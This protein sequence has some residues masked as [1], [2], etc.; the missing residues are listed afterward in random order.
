MIDPTPHL[1]ALPKLGPYR[2]L[3]SGKVRD[4]YEVD[5][6]HLLFVT[7]DRVSAFD[8]IMP[9]GIPG[10]GRVLTA[11][12]THWFQHTEDIL[13]NHLVS[14]DVEGLPHHGELSD[15]ERALLRGRMMLVRK[16][17]PTPVEWVVRAYVCGSGWKEYEKQGTICGI[18]L[19]AGIPFCGRLPEPL[20]GARRPPG[21]AGHCIHG[22]A[23]GR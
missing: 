1:R 21:A 8:V 19:P 4:I 17:E 15:E 3:K 13:E 12:A 10:K 11:V 16:A 7:S 22:A 2:L 18:P 20:P 6:D 9:Q 23:R 14:T 5:D